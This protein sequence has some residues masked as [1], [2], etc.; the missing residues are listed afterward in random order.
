MES[1][2]LAGFLEGIKYSKCL[3]KRMKNHR[4]NKVQRTKYKGQGT[5]TSFVLC[6]LYFSLLFTLYDVCAERE[7][8]FHVAG[9]FDNIELGREVVEMVDEDSLSRGRNDR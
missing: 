7:G 5:V 9:G 3:L 4:K 2:K 6:S 1:P 8:F